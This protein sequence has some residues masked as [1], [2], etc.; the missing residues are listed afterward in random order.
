MQKP[1]ISNFSPPETQIKLEVLNITG[2][3]LSSHV[4]LVLKLTYQITDLGNW[5]DAML[6]PGD[7]KLLAEDQLVT[8]VS[9]DNF[10]L[11]TNQE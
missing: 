3:H 7:S 11:N 9:E 1:K 10:P 4:R 2:F 5:I 6:L 8:A